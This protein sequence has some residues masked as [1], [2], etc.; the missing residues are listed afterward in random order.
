MLS[1]QG[2]NGLINRSK[3]L[4]VMQVTKPREYGCFFDTDRLNCK[5]P[6]ALHEG[7]RGNSEV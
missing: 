4:S 3:C 6:R 1:G 2:L 7:F 5:T